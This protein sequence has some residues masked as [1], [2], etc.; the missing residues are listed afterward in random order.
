MAG[1]ITS[2]LLS[3]F[4]AAAPGGDGFT[5]EGREA[6]ARTEQ[7]DGYYFQGSLPYS[8]LTERGTGQVSFS[9]QDRV[10]LANATFGDKARLSAS[11]RIGGVD[12]RVELTQTGFPP[13][14]AMSR[15]PPG[16]SLQRRRT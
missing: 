5:F 10:G 7:S 12:Y 3:G 15:A 8:D 16:R 2:I 4:L 11:L 14:Q 1:P 6:S 9:V 13:R